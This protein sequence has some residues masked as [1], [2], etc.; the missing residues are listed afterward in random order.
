MITMQPQQSN[1]VP[2]SPI[3]SPEPQ[4]DTWPMAMTG[5]QQPVP[6]AASQ[7]SNPQ[8]LITPT[9]A[10]DKDVIEREWV[11]A[12]KKVVRD[13]NNDPYILAKA[14][15][16]LKVQYMKQRYNEDIKTSE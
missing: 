8:H 14:L 7:P 6:Q 9:E 11:D 5:Q 16:T 2:S 10:N 3:P 4:G 1:Y 15:T 13:D 12:V